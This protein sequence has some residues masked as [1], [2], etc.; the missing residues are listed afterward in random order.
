MRAR[1]GK[2]QP[3]QTN[4]AV[5]ELATPPYLHSCYIDPLGEAAW[6]CFA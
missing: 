1:T 6:V 4:R 5:S 3:R 2:C